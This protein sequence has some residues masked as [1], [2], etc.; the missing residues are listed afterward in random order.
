M[1]T[2]KVTYASLVNAVVRMDR[3]ICIRDRAI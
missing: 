2:E 3:I 1:I